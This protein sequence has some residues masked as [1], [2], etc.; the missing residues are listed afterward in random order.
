MKIIPKPIALNERSFNVTLL[1]KALEALGLPVA[2]NEVDKNKAGND[3]LK[4][5]RTLQAQL[6]VPVDESTLVDEA[7]FLAIAESLNKRGLTAASRSF[8]VSGTVRLHTGEI[9]KHQRLLAFDL[10]LRGVSVFRTVKNI[11]EIQTN[12]GFE[13]LGETVSDILG[14]YSITF[15]EWQYKKAERKKADVVVYAIEGE[16]EITGLSRMVNSEDYS[17]KGLVR[18]LD[19]II[20]QE[21]KRTE[22]EALMSELKN[23]LKESETSLGEIA[24][25]NDQLVFTAGELDVDIMPRIHR[26]MEENKKARDSWFE[27]RRG[28]KALKLAGLTAGATS[29]TISQALSTTRFMRQEAIVNGS[30]Y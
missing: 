9:K 1:H 13:F 26:I 20:T 7:T 27:T 21:D 8:T 24:T 14:N 16:K 3:T 12:G 2:K 10:D 15:Y 23:F 29:A 25:S 30:H 22:Y 18:D 6:N 19:V 11:E 28:K 17:D 4:Q 5:V